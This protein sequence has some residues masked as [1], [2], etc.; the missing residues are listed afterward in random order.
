MPSKK[1]PPNLLFIEL[2]EFSEELLTFYTEKFKFKNFEK[3]LS[4]S[5]SH[6]LTDDTYESDYLEPWVQW[7]SVHTATPS[8][9]HQIKH[10]GDVPEL[11]QP[12][13]WEEMSSKGVTSGIWGAMNAS[14]GSAENCL[15]FLPDPWTDCEWAHPKEINALLDLL[16]YTSKNY[17]NAS[18]KELFKKAVKAVHFLK[19][20]KALK[21]IFKES[22][23]LLKTSQAFKGEAFPFISLFDL[24]S[25]HLFIRYKKRY[26]PKFSLIFLNS[27]AH[28]QH[29]H[30]NFEDPK[31]HKRFEIGLSYLDRCLGMLLDSM[32]SEDQVVIANALSQK[33]TADEKPWY[34]YRQKDPEQFLKTIGLSFSRVEPHMTHDAHI[35]FDSAKEALYAKKVLEEA[36]MDH[37]PVFHVESYALDPLKIFYKVIFTDEL[38]EDAHLSINGKMLCFF[39]L[40][41]SIIKRKGRHIQKGTILSSL[42]F[43]EQFYNHE[44]G[45][46]LIEAVL[47]NSLEITEG[48]SSLTL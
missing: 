17:V 11:N 47:P 14:K 34:L 16:R 48:E 38:N 26:N 28:L 37:Q 15:F 46:F 39:D 8:S 18:K 10:L 40:F 44:L 19:K 42:D 32:E 35:Y 43:P 7:V 21:V 6:T 25:T 22:L 29:H 4:L 33:N 27:L 5:R 12:Q 30:W 13:I 1:N 36:K 41:K 2:N 23:N 20:E 24:V 31:A 3:I 45:K 9:R